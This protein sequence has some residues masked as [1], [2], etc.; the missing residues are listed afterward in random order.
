MTDPEKRMNLLARLWRRRPILTIA[1]GGLAFGGAAICIALL[2][3]A[4]NDLTREVGIPA[5]IKSVESEQ[6]L[7]SE[8]NIDDALRDSTADPA[9]SGS[10]SQALPDWLPVVPDSPEMPESM[11][12]RRDA[13]NDLVA[14]AYAS[15]EAYRRDRMAFDSFQSAYDRLSLVHLD[16]MAAAQANAS[17]W[18]ESGL[19]YSDPRYQRFRP[20]WARFEEEFAKEIEEACVRHGYWLY[21]GNAREQRGDWDEAVYYWRQ[22]GLYGRWRIVAGSLARRLSAHPALLPLARRLPYEGN[23]LRRPAMLLVPVKSQ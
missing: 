9:T 21:L 19:S 10:L 15:L 14:K 8:M 5:L 12:S 13:L 6:V 20:G 18:K 23:E 16:L 1:V 22:D 7:R 11:R 17:A 4:A 3:F 2:L